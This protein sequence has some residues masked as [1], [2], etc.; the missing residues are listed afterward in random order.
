MSFSLKEGRG[1]SKRKKGKHLSVQVARLKKRY[2]KKERKRG[3]RRGRKEHVPKRF[4]SRRNPGEGGR[5]ILREA[6][7]Q[8]GKSRGRD[9][10]RRRHGTKTLKGGRE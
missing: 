10:S 3:L 6:D 7:K 5:G 4:P 9:I 2:S 1:F 8:E